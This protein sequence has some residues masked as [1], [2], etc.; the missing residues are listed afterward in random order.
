VASVSYLRRKQ[1]R[2]EERQARYSAAGVAA[3]RRKREERAMGAECVGVVRFDGAM[4]GGRHEVRC[5]YSEDYSDTHLMVEVDGVASKART[6][7]GV[8]R[9][10]ARRLG[11][12]CSA[13]ASPAGTGGVI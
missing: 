13:G 7:G 1:K 10:L 6:V 12:L 9:L 8:Y 11:N 2:R 3:R 4:F 5:L